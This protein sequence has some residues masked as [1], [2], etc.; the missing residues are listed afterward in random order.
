MKNKLIAAVIA[1]AVFIIF[2]PAAYL[3]IDLGHPLKGLA[4]F[5]LMIA[6]FLLSLFIA[7]REGD[8]K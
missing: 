6:G 3:N 7:D 5:I 2:M 8:T 4:S 1:I